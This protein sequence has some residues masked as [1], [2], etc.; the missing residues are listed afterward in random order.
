MRLLVF[1][2]AA[3]C[4]AEEPLQSVR[5]VFVDTLNGNGASTEMRD[6]LITAL[7]NTKRFSLTENAER[8]DV[9][10][11]GTANEDVFTE[12]FHSSE[13]LNARAFVGSGTSAAAKKA[14]SSRIPADMSVGQ[15]ENT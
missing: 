1:L 8:A 4:L 13:S 9:M 2:V 10:L 11:R 15:N 5:R 14:T 7:Q 6:L 3:V 12:T